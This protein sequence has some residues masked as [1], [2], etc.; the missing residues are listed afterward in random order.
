MGQESGKCG[1]ISSHI[2]FPMY[3][4]SVAVADFPKAVQP[5]FDSIVEEFLHGFILIAAV[6]VSYLAMP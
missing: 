3:K 2:V 4:N 5:C 1:I 6:S